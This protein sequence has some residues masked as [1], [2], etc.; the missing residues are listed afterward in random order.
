ME[1][2]GVPIFTDGRWFST[3]G[4]PTVLFGAGPADPSDARGHGPDEN[5]AVSD[6]VAATEI[7]ARALLHLLAD[8]GAA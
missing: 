6:L 7:V 2:R 5:V 1:T 3:Q 4:I 8:S